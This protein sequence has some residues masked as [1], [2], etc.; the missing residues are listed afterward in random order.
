[1]G[2]KTA[3]VTG[4]TGFPSLKPSLVIKVNVG[5]ANPI[6]EVSNGSNHYHFA[7][8]SGTIKSIPG[9]GLDLDFQIVFGGDWLYFDADKGR[10]RVNVRGIAK[11]VVRL[12]PAERDN[13]DLSPGTQRVCRSLSRTLA[14]S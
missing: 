11:S 3:N 9:S 2:D 5:D 13:T 10:A 6:G 1:M 12:M 14:L 7:A 8:N 4:E